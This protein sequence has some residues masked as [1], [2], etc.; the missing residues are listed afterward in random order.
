MHDFISVKKWHTRYFYLICH[1]PSKYFSHNRM[2]LML[3]KTFL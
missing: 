2:T 3:F 1:F